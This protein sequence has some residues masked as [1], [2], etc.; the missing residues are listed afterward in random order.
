MT[1]TSDTKWSTFLGGLLLGS[2]LATG[3]L[4]F[5][6]KYGPRLANGAENT[7]PNGAS[8]PTTRRKQAR[9][10][11]PTRRQ[12]A[13]WQYRPGPP[14][15]A[16]G[17]AG[18]GSKEPTANGQVAPNLANG[19][20]HFGGQDGEE[21]FAAAARRSVQQHGAGP[22]GLKQD[23]SEPDLTDGRPL[24]TS[25]SLY[26][27]P[28]D[29][30]LAASGAHRPAAVLTGPA[31]R[32]NAAA[33]QFMRAASYGNLQGLGTAGAAAPSSSAQ[34]QPYKYPQQPDSARTAGAT[35]APGPPAQPPPAVV[36]PSFPLAIT[37]Q[38]PPSP[39]VTTADAMASEG[40]LIEDAAMHDQYCR[41]ITPEPIPTE[42]TEEVCYLLK[43][44]MDLRSKWLFRPLLSPEQQ[45][46]LPEATTFSQ[47]IGDPFAY[48]PVEAAPWHYEMEGGVMAVYA[49]TSK[50]QLLFG[51]P[52]SAVDFF[53]DMHW[54][55]KISNAG[56]VRTFTHHRL[57]LLEQ[58]FNLHVMLNAD[59]EFLAQKSA[60]HRDFY[61]VRKVDTHVHHSACMHQKHLLRF[62]KSK[63]KKEADEVV[64]FR[65]GK[66]LTLKEVFESLNLTPYDLNVDNLDVHADK[67][68][69][70]RFDKFN[71]KY[72][73]FGQ[74]R[75]REIFIKQDNLIH[76]RF[77]AELTKEVFADLE[78]SKYQHTEY[79][80]SVYG[81]KPVEWDTL[82]AWVVQ[83]RLYSDNNA[84]LI[85]IPRLY[86]V[87]KEQGIID[88]FEQLLANIFQP[89]FEVTA[90]PASHPQ[91]HIFLQMVVGFD[92]VDDES[93]PERRP[94]KHMPSPRDWSSKHNPAYAYYAYYMYANLYVLN[95]MREARGFS[96]FTLRPHAGE[97]GDI[98][99]LVSAFLLAE[100]IAHGINLRKS[101]SLQ[102]LFYMAQIGLCMSPLSNNSLFLDYHRNPFPAFFARG[103]S[104]SLSTDDPL[105]IHL[106][107]EPLV[108]EYSVAAQV[109]KMSSTDLC[110][111]ARNS[112]VHSGFP[113]Q[114]KMHWVHTTYWRP[115]PEGN[116][117]Q[118][119]N[120]P[121]LR[122]RFRA[123]CQGEE[124]GLVM[125]GAANHA[126][127]LRA[128]EAVSAAVPAARRP[129][130]AGSGADARMC[131]QQQQQQRGCGRGGGTGHGTMEER[132]SAWQPS[133]HT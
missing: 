21:P 57:L 96:T 95:K 4:Y 24:L 94:N 31:N 10:S 51:P 99:H 32:S 109:W 78:A 124:A 81:R 77:L 40:R 116:N 7:G 62:I 46:H 34:V 17:T 18:A 107:K 131:N 73:P 112:V 121:A 101:P 27:Q 29:L 93:K 39:V 123:D 84:W 125:S 71:L 79:R 37:A 132:R 122:L 8:K 80:I 47:L 66:Y 87:Y 68:I 49:D 82:A 53:T 9:S 65:D 22:G 6:A 105:Q 86:N 11:S 36:V 102:Y 72:N 114:V 67:N 38:P 88:N 75:L 16:A 117:I 26:S 2:T 5:A 61:N 43:Q 63:L 33:Q 42:E 89:L 111:I 12:Q 118:K 97:A 92:L 130:E 60:P 91:L 19:H 100:N 15:G 55:L 113:H 83:N 3:A 25:S 28:S 69:F 41:V 30:A 104:V 76:G 45:A 120:V 58:K 106:T 127:R 20:A 126:A 103:L 98:D 110:E 23:E 70:H 13:F 115:G 90:D 35:A 85:Q 50:Q 108:E 64:I 129:W 14:A 48:R 74:S 56:H 1:S 44:A 54:L 59:K 119:T 133:E 52:G 128:R